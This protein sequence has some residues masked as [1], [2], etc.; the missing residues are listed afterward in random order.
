MNQ[1]TMTLDVEQTINGDPVA[2]FIDGRQALPTHVIAA[3][4]Y[5]NGTVYVTCSN[6]LR[7][8][9]DYQRKVGTVYFNGQWFFF[10]NGE[11]TPCAS[12]E[13][14]IHLGTQLAV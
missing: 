8:L 11:L 7:S 5:A 10:R 1:Y 9:A 4:T 3:E 6:A 2:L 13:S 14:A 12:E